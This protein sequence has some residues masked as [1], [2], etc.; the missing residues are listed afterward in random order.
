MVFFIV[1]L[2]K[3]NSYLTCHFLLKYLYQNRKVSSLVYVY[4]GYRN[5]VGNIYGRSSIVIAHFVPIR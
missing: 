2:D 3:K 1:K 4:Q 5:L